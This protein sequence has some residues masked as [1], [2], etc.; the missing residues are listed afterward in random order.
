MSTH[1]WRYNLGAVAKE[2]N[3]TPKEVSQENVIWFLNELSYIHDKTSH[4]NAE[5]K[6]RMAL[7][8][9]RR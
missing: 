2:N 4:D 1:G 3:M 7:M 5:A 8:K 9:T 6:R